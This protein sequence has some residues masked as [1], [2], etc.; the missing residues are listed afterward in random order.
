[1]SLP[2]K[3]T[4]ADLMERLGMPTL[5]RGI[6]FINGQLSAMPGL[7]PDL[8][9]VLKDGDRV[10]FF[11]LK[12]MWPFQYRHGAALP[13]RCKMPWPPK[14]RR[15]T[16]I[17]RDSVAQAIPFMPEPLADLETPFERILCPYL[18]KERRDSSE[19][20]ERSWNVDAIEEGKY[21]LTKWTLFP[22]SGCV[23]AFPCAFWANT[24]LVVRRENR[25][26]SELIHA[27]PWK[28]CPASMMTPVRRR[29][30]SRGLRLWGG[31]NR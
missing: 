8:G 25:S 23:E 28:P 14:G 31:D 11:D 19:K 20:G 2:E 6:T 18:C 29:V 1:M 12:S 7:Q 15:L 17:L 22:A 16:H 10:A 9:H 26:S 3:S 21:Q 5:E 13:K 4:L 27:S 24:V 30:P